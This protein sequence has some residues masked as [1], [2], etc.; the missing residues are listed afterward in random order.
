MKIW[1]PAASP[2]H[3]ANPFYPRKSFD[4]HPFPIGKVKIEAVP[5]AISPTPSKK[6]APKAKQP[7]AKKPVRAVKL[8]RKKYASEGE[9]LDSRYDELSDLDI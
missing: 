5:Q 8:P 3:S 7:S 1:K 6:A 2:A 4:S 9:V